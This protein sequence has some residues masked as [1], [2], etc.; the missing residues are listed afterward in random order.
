MESNETADTTG[1]VLEDW[2][3]R[4]VVERDELFEKYKKLRA[5][6]EG[7]IG[8]A[9]DPGHYTLLHAQYG[10]MGAYLYILNERI[11]QFRTAAK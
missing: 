7:S 1:P 10:A 6:L 8:K 9:F 5:F 4:V 2:Q 3:K 11:T